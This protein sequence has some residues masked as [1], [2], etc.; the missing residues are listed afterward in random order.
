MFINSSNSGQGVANSVPVF[1]NKE[2]FKDVHKEGE[3]YYHKRTQ[4][5]EKRLDDVIESKSVLE[6]ENQELKDKMNKLLMEN[7]QKSEQ[8]TTMGK[9]YRIDTAG[10]ELERGELLD[11][12]KA[13]EQKHTQELVSI[14]AEKNRLESE[15]LNYIDQ[16]ADFEEKRSRLVQENIHLKDEISSQDVK[17]QNF[18]K[19]HEFLRKA[20]EILKNKKESH[21]AAE[22]ELKQTLRS[23]L[24]DLALAA[25]KAMQIEADHVK[26]V[27]EM[28]K[29]L[30]QKLAE[31]DLNIER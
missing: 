24:E 9:K 22:L 5:L 1:G 8:I 21:I 23:T 29:Q 15:T 30:A 25:E 4:E 17:I 12:F 18:G 28:E 13:M 31:K 10:Y 19:N 27:Q 20:A 6:R 7:Q 14:M 2:S 16:I 11:K 3:E 26:I